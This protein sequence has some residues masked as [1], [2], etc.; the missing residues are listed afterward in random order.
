M[1]MAQ[2]FRDKS[3]KE[4]LDS[5]ASP[6][7]KSKNLR[8]KVARTLRAQCPQVL[9]FHSCTWTDRY[10]DMLCLQSWGDSHCNNQEEAAVRLALS[11]CLSGLE[12]VSPAR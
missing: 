11:F 9:V 12:L 8:R 2:D 5:P 3:T 6:R 4:M 1:C 10:L 7:N